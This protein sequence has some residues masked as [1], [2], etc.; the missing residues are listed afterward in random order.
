MRINTACSWSEN[1]HSGSGLF[2]GEYREIVK[3]SF[4]KRFSANAY[5]Q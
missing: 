1:L 2:W 5:R 4:S 3:S